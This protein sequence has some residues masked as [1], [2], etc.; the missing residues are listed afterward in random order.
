M[1]KR[2][3]AICGGIVLLLALGA[4][5]Q[6]QDAKVAGAWVM[7]F[8]GRG[9]AVTATLT[10][11]QDGSALKGTMK[12]GDGMEAALDGGTVS[13]NDITFSVTRAGRDG[14]PQKTDYKGTVAGDAITGTFMRGQNSVDW[15]AKRQ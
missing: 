5:A 14:N 6:A 3:I 13:G 7:S 10:L 11:T 12:I 15:T 2:M 9:G 8:A 4:I 1:K